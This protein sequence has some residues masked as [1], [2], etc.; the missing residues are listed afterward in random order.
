MTGGA[1][2]ARGSGC[3]QDLAPRAAQTS[4]PLFQ[5][6]PKCFLFDFIFHCYFS[7][8]TGLRPFLLGSR[9]TQPYTSSM[10]LLEDSLF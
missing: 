8:F 9:V 4:K 2:G 3:G 5:P 1:A 6:Q 10:F 7:C